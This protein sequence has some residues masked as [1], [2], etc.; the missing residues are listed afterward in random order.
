MPDFRRIAG[1]KGGKIFK[2]RVDQDKREVESDKKFVE[3]WL[4]SNKEKENT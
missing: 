1:V 2:Q 3:K 4:S